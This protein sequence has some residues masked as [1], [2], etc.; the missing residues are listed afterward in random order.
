ML[1]IH[2]PS[3]GADRPACHLALHRFGTAALTAAAPDSTSGPAVDQ[4]EYHV[5]G[6]PLVERP[7]GLRDDAPP[8]R[9]EAGYSNGGTVDAL[10]LS[11]FDDVEM[12]WQQAYPE[13]FGASFEPV[14][15]LGVLQLAGSVQPRGVLCGNETYDMPNA[16]WCSSLFSDEE[17]IAWD[18]G[19]LVPTG[20][21]YFGDTSIAALIAHE[22]GHAV[23]HSASIV[24]RF[25]ETIVNKQ[26]ALDR[27]RS[28]PT[29]FIQ[30][31]IKTTNESNNTSLQAVA[32]HS[33]W[34]RRDVS[35]PGHKGRP[36]TYCT[37][38]QISESTIVFV[39]NA[40]WSATACDTVPGDSSRKTAY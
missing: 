25:T 5:R 31:I 32:P 28:L 4:V 38:A 16:M 23:Q 29:R 14:N 9:R 26:Q 12:F 7:S 34:I 17:L 33:S 40:G 20:R 24:N 3:N 27:Q 6:L 10:V 39:T 36:E 11:A 19:F 30:C 37:W 35:A 22:H 13:T 18:R 21:Q 8:P 2:E 1:T 15:E